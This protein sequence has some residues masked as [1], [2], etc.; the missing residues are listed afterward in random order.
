MGLT[1][2]SMGKNTNQQDLII[3]T[4]NPAD[5]IIGLAGN[6][7]VGKSTVFNALTGLNQHTGNW[8][9][10]TVT[11]A[12]GTYSKEGKNYILVDIPGTYS[13]IPHSNEEEVARNFICFD[14]PDAIIVVCDAT[15]LER[16][17]NLV[18]QILEVTSKVV[19]CVNLLDEANK[20]HIQLDLQKLSLKLGVPVVGTNARNYEGLD[21]LMNETISLLTNESATR[22]LKILYPAPIEEVISYLEPSLS[23]ILPDTL[24][25][26]FTALQI[27]EESPG[28]LQDL[29]HHLGHHFSQDESF[30]LQLAKAKAYLNDCAISTL[31]FKDQIVSHIIHTAENICE[32]I[33]FEDSDIYTNRDLKID[34]VLTSKRSGIPTMIILLVFSLWLTI[35]GANYPSTLLFNL[36]A[37][38]ENTL[39]A[40]LIYIG[41]PSII[42][43]MLIYGIYRV[44]T[45]VVA[46]MLPPMAIFF[47]LFTLLEDLG[48]LPRVAFNL[49]R[50]LKKCSA[51]G[52]QALT[53][54]MGL[55]CNAAG[56][57]GCR[58]IDSPRERLIAIITNNFIPCNGRFPTFI[59]IISMFFMGMVI[60]PMQSLFSTLLLTGIILLGIAMTFLS[61]ILLSRTLLKGF[62]SSFTLELPPYRKP[63]IVKVLVRSLLDRT[64]YVLKR[65][66]LV[67]APA[68]LIIWLMANIS[69]NDVSLL[70]HCAR[71]LDPFA[72][73]LGLDGI[74]L[75]A[76]ILGFPANE[77][78]VPIMI[79]AYTS[80]GYLIQ[81]N[82][83]SKLRLLLLSNGWTPVTAICMM[84]FLL[85]HWP[86]STTCLTIKK[87]T[88]SLKW[89]IIS[90]LVPTVAGMI[91]C[92][93]VATLSRLFL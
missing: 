48:Y 88:Q 67:A 47:P 66:V 28:F 62:S 33:V 26:R 39:M 55:G 32:D 56:V 90:M 61:S 49:D 51:C 7:N 54:C 46:V 6:P 27:L 72:R 63:Q 14:N 34:K 37:E 80:T 23:Q 10:K 76:F 3:T 70:I 73:L 89:T 81:V 40:L 16:N 78:V 84:L 58:I 9:G 68:G 45:W 15:C 93:I 91:I 42:C 71:F 8:P 85:M 57:V 13:L 36:F 50:P 24:S 12:Q 86:C 65:A 38:L 82:D 22:P 17:L 25:P 30:T 21:L 52:K 77:V 1:S 92:F 79:M 75:I 11:Q 83:L 2:S 35:V 60:T 69:V 20:K 18:L 64:L 59:S 4:S 43:E 19:V 53:M 31:E 29:E 41:T 74:I 87:E 5:Y 44:L